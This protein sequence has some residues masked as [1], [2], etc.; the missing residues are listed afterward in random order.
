MWGPGGVQGKGWT[1]KPESTRQLGKAQ[2][3]LSGGH[4]NEGLHCPEVGE[5]L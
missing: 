1:V 5:A 4:V 3:V 2:H